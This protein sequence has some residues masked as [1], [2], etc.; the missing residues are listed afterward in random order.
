MTG[1]K[2]EGK[3]FQT[4]VDWERLCR[5][6]D[7]TK[8]NYLYLINC[9]YDH[10]ADNASLEAFA[11]RHGL[12]L[13][14]S[15][16]PHGNI[17]QFTQPTVISIRRTI[18]DFMTVSIKQIVHEKVL[19]EY[20]GRV[21]TLTLVLNESNEVGNCLAIHLLTTRKR[22]FSL[23]TIGALHLKEAEMDTLVEHLPMLNASEGIQFAGIRFTVDQFV[24]LT[25]ALAN[26][27]NVMMHYAFLL[28]TPKEALQPLVAF[29]SVHR[30]NPHL[31]YRRGNKD[32]I[33]H[34]SYFKAADL[35]YNQLR[36]DAT[37]NVKSK[38]G[39][40]LDDDMRDKIA[41]FLTKV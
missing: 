2:I 27:K 29:G 35:R 17:E 22:K 7:L 18:E 21:K 11:V 9:H 16:T 34:M 15:D 19:D 33:E 14:F 1:I 36:V 4:G 13:V 10:V 28:A 26:H 12:M 41:S 32:N 6:V 23:F 31:M 38:E 37:K 8:Y 3:R 24:Q 5:S 25:P 40:T 20:L 39:K 30:T